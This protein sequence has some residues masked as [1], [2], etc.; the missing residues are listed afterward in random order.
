MTFY[1]SGSRDFVEKMEDIL[2]KQAGLSKR[3][4]Y[5]RPSGTS[6]YFKYAHSDSIKL[7]HYMYDGVPN[8]MFLDRKYEKFMAGV[9]GS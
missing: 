4:I 8:Y 2:N 9:Y 3:V 1:V 5:S 6:F 7:F